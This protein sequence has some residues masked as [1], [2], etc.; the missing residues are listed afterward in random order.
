MRATLPGDF[1]LAL[2]AP[3]HAVVSARGPLRPDSELEA[4][5]EWLKA[6]ADALQARAVIIHTPAELTPGA[7][8]R[9]LLREYIARL[10]RVSGRH[11]VWAAQGAW[12]P[13]E[14]QRVCDEL[15]L[16]RA[17]DP[18]ES[19]ASASAVVYATLRALGHRA[20]FSYASLA[21]AV[22]RT[23]EHG[24][25][26]AFISVD[27]ERAFDI[28]RRLRGLAN[29]EAAGSDVAETSDDEGDFEDED[30]DEGTDDDEDGE[31]QQT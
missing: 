9:D 24:P 11:Y 25:E 16:C 1:A 27:A 28:A 14:A 31:D 12:E 19:R 5:L 26:E 4:G 3:R 2:R 8:S 22:T 13:E 21:D 6:A 15:G 23:L 18:L 29:Q 7:R 17:F 20:G 30:E 10:P